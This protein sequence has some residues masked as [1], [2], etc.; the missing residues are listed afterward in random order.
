MKDKEIELLLQ[1]KQLGDIEHLPQR[2]EEGWKGSSLSYHRWQREESRG[3]DIGRSPEMSR[4]T[5]SNEKMTYNED[6]QWGLNLGIQVLVGR[7]RKD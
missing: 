7:L 6:S 5:T 1:N 3:G 2:S 4:P